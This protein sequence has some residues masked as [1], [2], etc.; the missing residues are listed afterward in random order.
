MRRLDQDLHKFEAELN[1]ERVVHE[2]MQVIPPHSLSLSL[3]LF[4]SLSLSFSL[5]LS[6]SL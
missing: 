3:S 4:L 6:L 1:K 5:S 2:Q